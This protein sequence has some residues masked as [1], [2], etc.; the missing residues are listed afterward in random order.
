MQKNTD[1]LPT[2]I[3]S[4]YYTPTKCVMHDSILYSLA[5]NNAKVINH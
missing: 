4:A 1:F 2:H 5:E 3:G